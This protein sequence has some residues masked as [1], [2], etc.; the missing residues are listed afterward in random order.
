[1]V[2]NIALGILGLLVAFQ[3]LARLA[4]KVFHATFPAPALIGPFLNSRFRRMIQ[5][6][7][8]VLRQSGVQAGMS[9]LDF[10][11][12]SGGLTT[13]LARAVGET[14][15]VFA[16][17]I[18]LNML[19]QLQRKLGRAEHRDI[20]NI[21]PVRAN[22]HELPFHDDS[23]DL[24][25]VV[26]VLQEVPDP[27]RAL[28]EIKRVLKQGGIAAVSEL[29]PDP[30]YPLRSTTVRLGRE[31]GFHLD[32]ASGSFFTYTVRFTKP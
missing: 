25:M 20:H 17:D 16:L 23:L 24:V 4:K 11:C 32:E 15:C 21:Q 10:G 2:A 3:V 6:P 7:D 30:D 1:M 27:S 31:A 28:R 14:G 12:G 5:P 13:F 9:A 29:L 18:Q 22:A 19:R 26:G 8:K